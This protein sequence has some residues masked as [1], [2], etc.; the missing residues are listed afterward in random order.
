[1][2]QYSSIQNC[3]LLILDPITKLYSVVLPSKREKVLCTR[4]RPLDESER[5]V[6]SFEN[7]N[8]LCMIC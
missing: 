4:T 5:S 7:D 6:R 3:F 2:F 8:K 1:M